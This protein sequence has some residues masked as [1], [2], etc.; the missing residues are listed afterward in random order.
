MRKQHLEQ[1]EILP[2]RI[3]ASNHAWEIAYSFLAGEDLEDLD[4]DIGPTENEEASD[5]LSDKK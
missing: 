3:K 1:E 5:H 2:V 4:T